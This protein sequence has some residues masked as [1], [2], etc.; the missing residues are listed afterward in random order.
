GQALDP[1]GA[2]NNALPFWRRLEES[3]RY[4][5]KGGAAALVVVVSLLMST[6]IYLPLGWLWYLIVLG[7]FM[8]YCFSCLEHTARG[9]LLPPD[10][11][12]GYGGGLSLLLNLLVM[13]VVAG[14]AI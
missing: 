5:L 10:I 6:V 12:E 2:A 7:R 8:K 4:P 14:A 13:F 3:F 9:K 1:L 11:T